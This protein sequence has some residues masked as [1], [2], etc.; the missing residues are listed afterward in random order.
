L[1]QTEEDNL[2]DFLRTLSDS[3]FLNNPRFKQ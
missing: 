1:S 3:S 2:I